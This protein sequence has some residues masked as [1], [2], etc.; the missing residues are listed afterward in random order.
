M[1]VRSAAQLPYQ[2][3]IIFHHHFIIF[4]VSGCSICRPVAL[5]VLHYFSSSF[6]YFLCGWLFDLPPSCP[7]S[8]ALL[9]TIISSFFVWVVVRSAYQLPYQYCIIVHHHF[10]IF[11]VGGCSICRPVALPVLH[12][13]SSSFHYFL[14]GWLFDLPPSCPTSIALL[15]TIISSFFVWVV[16]RSAYQLPYRV[17]T[18]MCV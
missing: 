17:L 5:P 3:C 15:F 12:Y 8:I 14:C 10:I 11:C 13:C 4:C 7:T 9:F 16:V 6:H 18:R 1:V 2:Y